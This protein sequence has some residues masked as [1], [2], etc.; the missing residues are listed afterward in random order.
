MGRRKLTDERRTEIAEGLYR[1]IV[2]RG[3]AR[4]TVRDIAQEADVRAGIIH[5]YFE[6]KD[7]ILSTLTAITFDRH[8]ENLLA[9]LQKNRGRQPAERLRMGIDFIFLRV[10]GDRDLIQVFHELWNIAE[11]HETLNRSLKTLYREYRNA[12]ATLIGECFDDL[13]IPPAQRRDLAAFLVSASE[14][15]SIQWFIDPKGLSLRKLAT[16]AN[17]MVESIASAAPQRRRR[18]SKKELRS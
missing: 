6:S 1:C 5:H 4:T 9:L 8:K 10:A 18:A 3:Y 15:A 7:D 16:L 11:H 13:A 17:R 14:G 2:K 12:V